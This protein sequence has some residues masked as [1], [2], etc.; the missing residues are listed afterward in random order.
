MTLLVD[1][2]APGD[3]DRTLAG[4]KGRNLYA[5]KASGFPV[6]RFAV[7]GA[8]AFEAALD[9]L[10][11]RVTAGP[12]T[13]QDR[14]RDAAG[15]AAALSESPVPESVRDEISAALDHLGAAPAAVRSSARQ[16]DGA[17]HSFAGLFASYLN[18]SGLEAVEDAVRWC[19][20]SAFSPRVTHYRH[21][22]GLG[23]DD[24]AMAVIVQH[25]IEPVSS[26]VMFTADPVTG[27]TDHIVISGVPGLGEGLVS[28][29]V[30]SDSVVIDRTTRRV[31]D[32]VIAVKSRM[33]VGSERGGTSIVPIPAVR[34]RESAVAPAVRATLIDMAIGL[35][36]HF[37]GPQDVE[38]AHDGAVTWVVQTRPITTLDRETSPAA[39]HL[40]EEVAAD[41]QRI[42]DNSNI[43]ESFAGVT[44]PLTFTVARQLYG[45][46][47]R[48]YA[49]S[50]N[51]PRAQLEQMESWLPVMLGQFNG[52]VYYNLLHWYRMV[53]IAP[54]YALNRRV[55][56]VALGVSEPLDS[57]Q[58]RSL[59]P[60]TFRSVAAKVAARAR[61][62]VTYLRRFMSVD[63]MIREFDR[64]FA[65]FIDRH[66]LSDVT[67]LD[68]AAA[69]RHF[70][71]THNEVAD[72]WG[73][74]LVLDAILLTSVGL[75]AVLMKLFLSQAP[76]WVGF[77]VLN[78]GAD[79]VSVEPATALVEI[80]DFVDTVP[81]LRE[82]IDSV[83]PAVA[84]A[85]LAEIVESTD[86]PHWLVLYRKIKCYS[87]NYGY[88]CLDELKLEAPDL[89]DDPAGIF[90]LLRMT[91]ASESQR[92][93][94]DSLEEYL[95]A[96]LR[97]LRR[98]VFDSLRARIQRAATYREHLRFCRSRG[99]AL[100]KSLAAV[101]GRDLEQRGILDSRTDV[102]QLRLNELF[103]VYEGVLSGPQAQAVVA[104]RK[105]LD[106]RYRDLA[107]P[108]RIIT[109]GSS[110]TPA[111]LAAAGW[112]PA[113][114][115]A[116]A[117]TGT[118]LTGTPSC[119]GIVTGRAVVV[120]RPE[121]FSSGIL[122]AYRTEPGWAA[123]LPFA[124][125]LLVERASP[126]THVAIIA[127]ELGVPT[128]VQID[129]LT[130]AIRTGMTISVDGA[131]GRVVVLEEQP[132]CM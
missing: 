24:L 127:R 5:L 10:G 113:A 59:R 76:E 25:C 120:E 132:S 78:P 7:L 101:M 6:P 11:L 93:V 72:L 107:A 56:E 98:R 46:V 18:L 106:Q 8:D 130:E 121:D 85:R 86:D 114:E 104:R 82:F 88:R 92:G 43:I 111:E 32:E 23:F 69:Y 126:L 47:Y 55:L 4:G 19:W 62:D 125:A 44:S 35:E 41:E 74:M 33:V 40:G 89:R 16:E 42:W 112:R 3:R 116:C 103:E 29:T 100:I 39:E 81:A 17:S 63:A 117:R 49:R 124:S 73:P 53:G 58:A 102:F 45:D 31:L 129:G 13:L 90:H 123:A 94:Q 115:S 2:Q 108:A 105:L 38:W 52:H 110:Y 64:T 60:F 68:G 22:R 28:G 79:V 122:V 119:P 54:G 48:A 27:R 131:T 1:H 50:L 26:G 34:Q 9:G 75:L 118:V 65:A 21:I 12:Q 70:R 51:V 97:G 20:A 61:I 128:V 80:A 84:D 15:M 109:R 36:R 66:G 87:E 83:N 96:H 30:D 14:L 91:R 67:G 99:F 77:A 71:Q 95:D 37:N 57:K